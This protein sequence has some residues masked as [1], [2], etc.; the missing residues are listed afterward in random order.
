MDAT[1][2]QRLTGK[3]MGPENEGTVLAS[4]PPGDMIVSFLCI[5]W[6]SIEGLETYRLF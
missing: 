4:D 1:H 5:L 2:A 6:S 3:K